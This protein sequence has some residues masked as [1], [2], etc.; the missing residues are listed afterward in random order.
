MDRK[1]NHLLL[2]RKVSIDWV[3]ITICDSTVPFKLSYIYQSRLYVCMPPFKVII[4]FA[5]Q[6]FCWG[7]CVRIHV[8]QAS[9]KENVWPLGHFL[10]MMD[11]F[12]DRRNTLH[13]LFSVMIFHFWGKVGLSQERVLFFAWVTTVLVYRTHTK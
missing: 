9:R 4:R 10:P 12:L 11:R 13:A 3:A 8:H 6:L 5:R 7:I 2:D 1:R